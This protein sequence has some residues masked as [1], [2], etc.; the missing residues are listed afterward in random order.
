MNLIRT[1]EHGH[2]QTHQRGAVACATKRKIK[3]G[4]RGRVGERE[5]G[6]QVVAN[7]TIAKI[8]EKILSGP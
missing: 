3:K 8:P 6:K 2:Q 7:K 5:K 1:L 4:K